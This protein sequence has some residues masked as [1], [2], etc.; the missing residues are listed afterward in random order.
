ML[1]FKD[2][3]N[4]PL[5]TSQ[6][7]TSV[8]HG[9]LAVAWWD[10][11]RKTF[12]SSCGDN[13]ES[14]PI[15]RTRNIESTS[16]EQRKISTFTRSST[17]PREY[18]SY[19]HKIDVHNHIRQGEL[20]LERILQTSNWKVRLIST[21]L[22]II[23]VDAYSMYK[24]DNEEKKGRI[25]FRDFVHEIGMSLVTNKFDDN[26]IETKKRKRSEEKE[27]PSE[28]TEDRPKLHILTPLRNHPN[29]NNPDRKMN[30]IQLSCY[31][32]SKK[33]SYYCEDCS[34]EDHAIALCNPWVCK[35][36]R[37]DVNNCYVKHCTRSSI[38]S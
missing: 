24:L 19:A 1:Y 27:K 33:T 36:K 16:G 18:F 12:I 10:K 35:D 25:S 17:V 22:G 23:L 38:K 8:Q 26:T 6:Y 32:C 31:L 20:A 34:T 21:I 3:N 29:M 37:S 15:Q 28:P 7:L 5:G 4:V 9:L 2:Q 13:K 14:K 30:R 11:S